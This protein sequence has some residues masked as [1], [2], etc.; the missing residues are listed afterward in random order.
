MW[1]PSAPQPALDGLLG[2]W[3]SEGD[4]LVLEVRGADLWARVPA[5]PGPVSETRFEADGTDR[6][7]AVEGREQ[8]ELLEVVR[9]ARGAV[10]RLYLATYPLTR[11]PTSFADLRD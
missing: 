1:T 8:G 9:D 10:T 6:F 7:R 4:E 2:S 11:E 5:A 3:W